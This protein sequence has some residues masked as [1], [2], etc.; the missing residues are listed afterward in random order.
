MYLI[1]TPRLGLRNWIDADL[2]K[3]AEM[4]SDPRVMEYFPMPLSTQQ[5]EQLVKRIREHIKQ[6]GFGVWATEIKTT[7]EFIGF[8]GLMIPAFEASFTPCVEIGWRLSYRFWG[9]GYASEAATECL[10]FGFD[11]LKLSEIVSFTSVI[12]K[13]SIHVMQNIGMKYQNDFEHPLV[14]TGN[15]LRPHVL[16]VKKNT[17]S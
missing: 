5:T 9:N 13:R 8:V 17:D 7:K 2:L 3:F 6:N 10:R 11:Q 4:N 1:E 16:Y 14:E 12:N 15:R